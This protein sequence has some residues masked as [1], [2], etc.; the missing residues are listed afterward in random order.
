M[1]CSARIDSG[2]FTVLPCVN[3]TAN[4]TAN[5]SDDISLYRDRDLLN[6]QN[7]INSDLKVL[8][9]WLLINNLSLRLGKAKYILFK[10]KEKG[11]QILRYLLTKQKNIIW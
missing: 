10:R 3:D 4:D 5:V 11:V 2:T 8:A 7:F 1:W 9:L 6:A